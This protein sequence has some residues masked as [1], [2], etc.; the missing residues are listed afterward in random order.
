MKRVV[1]HVDRLVLRGFR[2]EDRHA[3]GVGVHGALAR[4]LAT[5]GVADRL[6]RLESAARLKGG[7]L[8]VA[9]GTGSHEL[10]T[11]A[12]ERIVRSLTP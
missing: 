12:G 4:L 1:L 3:I 2:T 7:R 8:Q 11:R 9:N 10:G 6:A 5:P